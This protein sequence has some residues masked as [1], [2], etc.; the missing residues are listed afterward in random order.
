MLELPERRNGARQI[1]GRQGGDAHAGP[2][3]TRLQFGLAIVEEAFVQPFWTF[4]P[5]A[6]A[7]RASEDDDT[8]RAV[9]YKQFDD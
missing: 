7:R 8:R 3:D 5:N 6:I 2:I 9:A 1:T 4:A